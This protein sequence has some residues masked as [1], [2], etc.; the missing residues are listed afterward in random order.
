MQGG[1][2]R[3]SWEERAADMTSMQESGSPRPIRD[4]C[5]NVGMA[6]A[7]HVIASSVHVRHRDNG[8]AQ[9]RLTHGSA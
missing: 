5:S 6:T 1:A 7:C 2:R 8:K 9:G 3:C 4:P